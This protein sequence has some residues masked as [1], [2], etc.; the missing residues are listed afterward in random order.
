MVQTKYVLMG[1]GVILDTDSH[2]SFL[3][4]SDLESARMYEVWLKEGN[5]PSEP[6]FVSVDNV[7]RVPEHLTLV[8]EPMSNDDVVRALHD[9]H[10][11]FEYETPNDEYTAATVKTLVRLV[12]SKLYGTA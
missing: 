7:E 9:L 1:D 11:Y 3:E 8:G 10:A 6:N 5:E 4:G 12:V 2:E